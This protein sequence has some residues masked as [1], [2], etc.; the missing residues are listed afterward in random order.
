[1][2]RIIRPSILHLLVLACITI[3]GAMF[4]VE[5]K[6]AMVKGTVPLENHSTYEHFADLREVTFRLKGPLQPDD[7]SLISVIKR[8]YLRPPG[9]GPYQLRHLVS[10]DYEDKL[11][12]E[13]WIDSYLRDIYP[14]GKK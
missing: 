13:L 5:V 7:P 3:F 2:K 11:I 6:F 1:M 9:S 14:P 8:D 10:G 12:S 4:V